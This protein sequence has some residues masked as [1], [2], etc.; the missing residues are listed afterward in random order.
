MWYYFRIG[1]G[2]Y[3]TFL[4][5]FLTTTVTV[6]YLAI[7]S[8]PLLEAAF[9]T[10]IPFFIA[11]VLVGVPVGVLAGWFHMKRSKFYASEQDISVESSPY[12]YKLPPGYAREVYAPMFMQILEILSR[13][14]ERNNLLTEKEMTEIEELKSKLKILREGGFA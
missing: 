9:P 11:A 7:R 10:F 14:A 8:A 3:L 4:L 6:Y 2:T 13:L 12:Y 5:G 1:Y